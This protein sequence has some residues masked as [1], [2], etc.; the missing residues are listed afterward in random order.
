VGLARAE[1]RAGRLFGGAVATALLWLCVGAARAD[2]LSGAR[3]VEASTAPTVEDLR[4]LSIEQLG[5]LQVTS[6]EKRPTAVSD[7][8]AAIYV[9][10]HEDIVRS[11][12]V[13]LPEILRLAP[14]LQVFQESASS[15]VVTA[16]GFSG[17]A[18]DQ[19]FSNLMLVL[20]DG[21]S[22]YNP[23]FTGVY[24]DMQDIIPEDIDRI[25][26]I[27]GPAG[28]LWGANAVN[29]VIN[30]ITKKA[31]QTQGGF[32]DYTN[33]TQ[34]R[35]ITGQFGGH[36]GDDFNF[37]VYGRSIT[38]YD[39]VT[40]SGAKA[41]D[42]WSKPQGGFRADWTPTGADSVSLLGDYFEGSEAQSGAPNDDIS[43]RDVVG[44]WDHAWSGGGTL[45]VLAYWDRESRNTA[46][47][48][49]GFSVDTYDVEAQDSFALGSRNT[50][51]AGVGYRLYRYDIITGTS[52][53]VFTPS[54]AD[55]DVVNIFAQDTVRLTRKLDLTLGLTLENDPFSGLSPMPEVRLAWKPL[56]NLLLWAAASKAIRSPA[57]F[58]TQ[59]A[60]VV[61]GKTLLQGN[62]DF[63]PERLTAY[64]LGTRV[65]P[66]S[67]WSVSATV[68]YDVY[69]DLRNIQLTPATLFPLTWG[70]GIQGPT[71]GIEAWTDYR[72]TD[73][74]RLTAGLD[75]LSQQLHFKPDAAASAAIGLTQDGDD[76]RHT[77]RLQSAWDLGQHVTFD[78]DLR[79]V[80]ALPAPFVPSYVEMDSRLAWKVTRKIELS[81]A[82]FNLLHARH[83]ELPAPADAVP[84]SVRGELRVAF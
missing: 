53:L 37:R 73:G 12:A 49:G 58:D 76:P 39:T 75:F 29:G 84:R 8:P 52:S 71:W 24:W 10:T 59:V 66:D 43:G 30:I 18:G 28:T 61:G 51:V 11:G 25:E 55:L 45:G 62:P 32:L 44:R 50:F 14:N 4:D 68:Y 41:D 80:D 42:E 56:D 31:S 2:A 83:Q 33:G 6:V 26:V 64:Q 9:I 57:P 15:F 34:E 54:R 38:E 81:V 7:S 16:R 36:I 63:L 74:W 82:G 70:N 35:T 21:R 79:Y 47:G 60:E 27:S 20:I 13:T 40:A 48:G 5:E 23:I 69:D 72:V 19:S 77:A 22:V 67:R 78:A 65:Q 46:D 17:N 1:R 3:P